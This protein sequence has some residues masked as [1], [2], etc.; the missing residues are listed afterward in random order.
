MGTQP[1][2]AHDMADNHENNHQ[3]LNENKNH[4]N[5][6][7]CE[8]IVAQ[9]IEYQC[10]FCLEESNDIIGFISPCN[11]KGTQEWVHRT[12]LAKYIVTCNS[13]D[14][15][16]CKARFLGFKQ[17]KLYENEY[18]RYGSF[19]LLWLFQAIWREHFFVVTIFFSIDLALNSRRGDLVPSYSWEGVCIRSW[20][21]AL[22]HFLMNFG[23]N[24]LAV[25][26]LESA[27]EIFLLAIVQTDCFT[28][29]AVNPARINLGMMVE[30]NAQNPQEDHVPRP[31]R[32]ERRRRFAG[33]PFQWGFLRR[34]R[35]EGEAAQRNNDQA[36]NALPIA[37]IRARLDQSAQVRRPR[38]T[39]SLLNRMKGNLKLPRQRR[40]NGQTIF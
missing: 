37:H 7:E 20:A 25:L 13:I 16:V 30:E 23:M 27:I 26:L 38:R 2:M 1:R 24:G 28:R 8:V 33:F 21:Y 10:R 32:N 29:S 15:P 34:A 36:R 22:L 6:N 40:V 11:C 3:I 31:A 35:I 12:C 18:L 17:A 4:S 19:F 39:H 14:C 5:I 9:Q